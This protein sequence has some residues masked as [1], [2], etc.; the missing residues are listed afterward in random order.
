MQERL[1]Y[2]G[3]K[4]LT[5]YGL[6]KIR[7]KKNDEGDPTP[8]GPLE[9][10]E[11]RKMLPAA[12]NSVK[13]SNGTAQRRVALSKRKLLLSTSTFQVCSFK[14]NAIFLI[15]CMANFIW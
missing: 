1:S 4:K 14:G 11:R 12:L 3:P 2:K 13:Q 15:F 9:T 6:T 5:I 8:Q 10:K 7:M